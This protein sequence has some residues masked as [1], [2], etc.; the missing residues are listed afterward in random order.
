V[1]GPLAVLALL[2]GGALL[3]VRQGRVFV[4]I[5]WAL[6]LAVVAWTLAAPS[7]DERQLVATRAI[8][9]VCEVGIVAAIATLFASFSSPFLTA[10]FTA[11]VFVIGRSV[12][13]MAHL[14]K[15]LFGNAMVAGGRAVAH[16]VPNL[17]LYVPARPLLLGQVA[18]AR[19]WP[20]VG[21]AAL[22]A[23]AYAAGLLVLGCMAFRKRDFS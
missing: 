3:R 8:L 18:D 23:V 6:L 20:Y 15:K 2:L 7:L 22:Y 14:P 11:L 4:W 16:V 13:T 17:H 12:D 5:P 1:V 19:P 9:A 10:A 21:A